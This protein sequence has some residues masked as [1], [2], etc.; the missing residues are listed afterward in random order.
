MDK[1]DERSRSKKAILGVVLAT[2][3]LAAVTVAMLG[4]IGA[5]STGGPYNNIEK[6]TVNTVL[7]GQDL[8]FSNTDWS[9]APVVYRYVSGNLENTYQATESGGRYYINN[10]NW[11]TTGAYY[12]N[13]NSSNYEAQL[14]VEDP[15]LP[16]KLKVKDREVTTIARSTNLNID[17]GGINL[18]DTDVVDLVI[19]GPNGQITEKNGQI[20]T[21][22]RKCLKEFYW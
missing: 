16:L 8:E 10:V 17:V 5:S 15:K 2:V 1:R 7:I 18:D 19:I 4:S 13:G 14:S 3:V 9:A 11:Q 21:G 12:V 22:N 6:D 20:F